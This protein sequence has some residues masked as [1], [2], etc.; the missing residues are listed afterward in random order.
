MHA[1]AEP[2]AVH[3]AAGLVGVGLPRASTCNTCK[4]KISTYALKISTFTPK[5]S[6]QVRHQARPGRAYDRRRV[7]GGL[8]GAVHLRLVPVHLR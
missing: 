7:A 1:E 5:I 4:L 2:A 8:K 3:A 6:T